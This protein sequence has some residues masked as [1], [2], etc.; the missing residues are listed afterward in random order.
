MQNKLNSGKEQKKRGNGMR[1]RSVSASKTRQLGTQLVVVCLSKSCNFFP[2]KIFFARFNP[3][4]NFFLL[5]IYFWNSY[6]VLKFLI[7]FSLSA[8]LSFEVISSYCSSVVIMLIIYAIPARGER[9]WVNWI[10][11]PTQFCGILPW[12]E[13]LVYFSARFETSK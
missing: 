10:F 8:S 11:Y 5:R 1:I 12:M 3:V 13:P 4:G 2:N 6:T 9:R 7:S